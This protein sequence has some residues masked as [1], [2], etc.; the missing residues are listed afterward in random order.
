MSDAS[1]ASGLFADAGEQVPRGLRVLAA[2]QNLGALRSTHR[3]T[4]RLARFAARQGRIYVFDQGFVIGVPGGGF[5][6]LRNGEY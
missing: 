3:P 4:S 2:A 6:L 5:A 1:D